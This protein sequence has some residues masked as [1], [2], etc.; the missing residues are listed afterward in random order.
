MQRLARRDEPTESGPRAAGTARARR[1][2]ARRSSRARRRP[3]RQPVVPSRHDQ[4]GVGP[5]GGGRGVRVVVHPDRLVQTRGEPPQAPFLLLGEQD[6]RVELV[7]DG[8][9]GG[10][11]LRRPERRRRQVPARGGP[12]QVGRR[13]R[14]ANAVGVAV[15]TSTPCRASRSATAAPARRSARP[16]SATACATTA[17]VSITVGSVPPRITTDGAGHVPLTR[18]LPRRAPPGGSRRPSPRA[19]ESV[20]PC[21]AALEASRRAGPGLPGPPPSRRRTRAAP[22]RTTGGQGSPGQQRRAPRR[23]WP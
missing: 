5:P 7:E 14:P 17:A 8:R 23:P 20:Q 6:R 21:E 16:A 1:G 3:P 18:R 10:T 19:R 11:D 15:V 4:R 12:E 13:S 9:A 22:A 2:L